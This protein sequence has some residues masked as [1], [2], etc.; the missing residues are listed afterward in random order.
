MTPSNPQ[1]K[2][3]GKKE[4]RGLPIRAPEKAAFHGGYTFLNLLNMN[5][6]MEQ[7]PN[8]S[9]GLL[10]PRYFNKKFSVKSHKKASPN[11]YYIG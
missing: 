9:S 10:A 11:L 3:G 8:L 1:K 7:N 2:G 5:W 6:N 4:K